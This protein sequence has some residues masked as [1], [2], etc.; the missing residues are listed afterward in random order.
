MRSAAPVN[1][2]AVLSCVHNR[3]EVTEQLIT[4]SSLP[5]AN[6]VVVAFSEIS[7][8]EERSEFNL[9]SPSDEL[10]LPVEEMI[11]ESPSQSRRTP[12][13]PPQT[14]VASKRM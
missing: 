5:P 1:K 8:P 14:L 13:H 12:T 2:E 10:Q 9:L 11:R 7:P 6:E 4:I 3:W